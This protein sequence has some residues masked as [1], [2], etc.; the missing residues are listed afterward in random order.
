M[1][2]ELK[3]IEDQQAKLVDLY[4]DSH[5]LPLEKLNER[6]DRL[7]AQHETIAKKINHTKKADIS[8][9]DA[10]KIL[11]GSTD[12]MQL[13]YEQQKTLVRKFVKKIVVYNDKIDIRWAFD[14]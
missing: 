5:D 14:I 8:S 7:A 12:I 13:D 4:L 6:R 9:T 1:K 3:K 11:S 10:K 2:K